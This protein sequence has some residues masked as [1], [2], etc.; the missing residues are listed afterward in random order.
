MDTPV[1]REHAPET[2]RD[3]NLSEPNAILT[4]M[5][6]RTLDGP[7]LPAEILAHAARAVVLADLLAGQDITCG[8]KP[9][10][11]S[12]ASRDASTINRG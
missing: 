2:L 4:T 12:D 10:A 11:R 8:E 6:I 1:T 5:R 3:S 9:S 7:P